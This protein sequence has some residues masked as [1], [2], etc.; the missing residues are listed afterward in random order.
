MREIVAGATE[1]R[2]RAAKE[3]E[4][5][6]ITMPEIGSVCRIK[7]SKPFTGGFADQVFKMHKDKWIEVRDGRVRRP[8]PAEDDL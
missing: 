8:A 7:V 2:A 1:A 3:T 6:T 5:K 4:F